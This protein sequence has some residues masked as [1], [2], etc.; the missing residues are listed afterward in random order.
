MKYEIIF[1]DFKLDNDR[2]FLRMTAYEPK[3]NTPYLAPYLH[4]TE[5]GFFGCDEFDIK[6]LILKATNPAQAIRETIKLF[7]E[8]PIKE[9]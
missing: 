4:C 5:S 1:T 8:T 7:D 3:G 2:R 6:W 9:D